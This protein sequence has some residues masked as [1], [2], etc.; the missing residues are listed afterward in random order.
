MNPFAENAY[1]NVARMNPFV[2]NGTSTSFAALTP[3]PLIVNPFI[4]NPYSNIDRTNPS[5]ENAFQASF[6][7]LAPPPLVVPRYRAGAESTTQPAIPGPQAYTQDPNGPSI[8]T[9]DSKGCAPSDARH[10]EFCP[11][12]PPSRHTSKRS[13]KLFLPGSKH[14][15]QEDKGNTSTHTRVHRHSRSKNASL[16]K[17]GDFIKHPFAVCS[18][19]H[20]APFH[21]SL[22]ITV[23]TP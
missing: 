2:H 11:A 1:L 8:T 9:Y 4:L 23:A 10:A 3:P 22:T 20:S 12:S 17:L 19:F 16:Q 7:A 6:A 15:A 13:I 21:S 14:D 18:P 5:A